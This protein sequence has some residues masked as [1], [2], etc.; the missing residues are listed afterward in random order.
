MR[1]INQM[2][3]SIRRAQTD[4]HLMFQLS[5]TDIGTRIIDGILFSPCDQDDGTTK[6]SVYL[7]ELRLVSSV[8]TREELEEGQQVKCR[9]FVFNDE[10]TLGR[11][12][13]IQLV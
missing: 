4:C 5:T 13:R 8:R 9:V 10:A 2:T 7:E 6:Y 1:T 11:K 12:V 3:K